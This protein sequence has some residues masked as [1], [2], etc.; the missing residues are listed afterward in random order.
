ME[1]DA[2]SPKGELHFKPLRLGMA[3]RCGLGT[4]GEDDDLQILLVWQV[5]DSRGEWKVV[6]DVSLPRYFV[7]AMLHQSLWVRKGLRPC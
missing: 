1:N 4:I 6:K 3:T 2:V 7:E 5:R